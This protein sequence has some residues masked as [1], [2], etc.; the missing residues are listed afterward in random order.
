[1]EKYR[2]FT[3]EI[4]R[5]KGKYYGIFYTPDGDFAGRTGEHVLEYEAYVE[6]RKILTK[7]KMRQTSHLTERRT[8]N[9]PLSCRGL[10]SF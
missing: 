5:E 7:Y 1:M 8:A 2:D 10:I 3:I 9:S 6:I 4:K